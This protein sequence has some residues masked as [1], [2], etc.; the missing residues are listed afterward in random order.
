MHA[1]LNLTSLFAAAASP[2]PAWKEARYNREDLVQNAVLL[3]KH[4][5]LVLVLR[6]EDAEM[7]GAYCD[8][9][10][11]SYHGNVTVQVTVGRTVN[12]TEGEHTEELVVEIGRGKQSSPAEAAE[13]AEEEE[14]AEVSNF[15]SGPCYPGGKEQVRDLEIVRKVS[16]GNSSLALKGR[17]AGAPGGRERWYE[18]SV[19]PQSEPEP[20][21]NST[22][23]QVGSWIDVPLPLKGWSSPS[24]NGSEWLAG[25]LLLRDP[26]LATAAAESG[27]DKAA[28]AKRPGVVGR[29]K[30][31]FRRSRGGRGDEGKAE[32]ED[33]PPAGEY[34]ATFLFEY[35]EDA[36]RHGRRLSEAEVWNPVTVGEGAEEGAVEEAMQTY[37]RGDSRKEARRKLQSSPP[38]P[39]LPALF[40]TST[41]SWLQERLLPAPP[42]STSRRR[43][44]TFGDSVVHVNQLYH[45]AFGTKQR[46]VPAHMPHMINRHVVAEMQQ[47]W[48]AEWEQTSRNRFRE[49]SDMQYGFSY[50]YYLFYRRE[51]HVGLN[52]G[53]LKYDR[54]SEASA[55]KSG[56]E[57]KAS[58][59]K[60][61]RQRPNNLL[62]CTRFLAQSCVLVF[63]LP[64]PPL[65]HLPPPR[66]DSLMGAPEGE[67]MKETVLRA[68]WDAEIDTD[69]DG[70]LSE[71]E[72][73]SLAAVCYTKTPL[74]PGYLRKLR[75]CLGGNG[76]VVVETEEGS[77]SEGGDSRGDSRGELGGADD[78]AWRTVE[79]KAFGF[80][81]AMACKTSM[82]GLQEFSLE[83][84]GGNRHKEAITQNLDEIAFQMIGDDYN[85]TKS[86]LDSVRARRPKF[87]CIN[88]NMENPSE[89]VIQLF[90]DFLT[91]FFPTR[92]EYELP[93]GLKNVYLRLD[94][95]RAVEFRVYA[96]WWALIAAAA[97]WLVRARTRPGAKAEEDRG[98][99]E[100]AAGNPLESKKKKK[101]KS[102]KVE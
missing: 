93:D 72:F 23:L 21:A 57:Q 39:P 71:N 55:N 91:N 59:N 78:P 28:R 79:G 56:R 47:L 96:A 27:G 43:L 76:T 100:A 26:L 81:E 38:P 34:C 32:E 14:A 65:P 74:P 7:C 69:G 3:K 66:Y 18:L 77:G 102:N 99:K 67:G 8:K 82:E 20:A 1:Y 86:Q 9:A 42:A 10:P 95:Y 75:R 46:K 40:A 98:E 50:F 70:V 44:D 90:A 37:L 94:E 53:D 49:S 5:A 88:D 35:A 6:Q 83:V 24:S 80:Q 89:E 11:G 52:K 33:A 13:A 12:G 29:I 84:G 54:A 62:L 17:V 2:P 58:A 92:S 61:W 31:L 101:K 60:S 15:F 63:A 64:D 97:M 36:K 4:G 30:N 68:V 85:D 25:T 22:G 48:P 19:G 51:A 73:L 16:G 41:L 87:I 45:R